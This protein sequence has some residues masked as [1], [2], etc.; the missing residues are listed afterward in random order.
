MGQKFMH[1]KRLAATAMCT[2]IGAFVT[3]A[4]A[5][6]EAP[7]AAIIA[8]CTETINQYAH[9]RDQ[10]D[11]ERYGDLF[12]EDAVFVFPGLTLTGREAI[13]KRIRDDDGTITSRHLTGSI[14][15][16]IDANQTI[17][18]RSYIHVYQAATP[19]SPGP[20]P[21]GKYILGEYHDVMRMT[22]AGCKIARRDTV[23]VF[24]S[25]M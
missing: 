18:A 7:R 20:I 17:T 22:D 6:P 11:A 5:A 21:A 4:S 14:V 13:A 15:V 24:M 1:I 9:Y 19:A 12:T 10:L 23:V 3:S 16:T 25:E 2:A 8:A